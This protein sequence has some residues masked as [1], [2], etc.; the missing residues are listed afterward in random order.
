MPHFKPAPSAL[1]DL[2]YTPQ[3]YC[4]CCSAGVPALSISER[5]AQGGVVR[6]ITCPVCHCQERVSIQLAED[7]SGWVFFQAEAPE[8][9]TG[10]EPCPEA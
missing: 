1:R 8:P 6:E 2:D 3:F 10:P 9:E 7:F 5:K 4:Q